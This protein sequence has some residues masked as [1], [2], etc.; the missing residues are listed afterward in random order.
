MQFFYGKAKDLK[1]QIIA[2]LVWQSL[3]EVT[4]SYIPKLP[5]HIQN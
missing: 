3:L 5:K 2:R 1:M 4:S